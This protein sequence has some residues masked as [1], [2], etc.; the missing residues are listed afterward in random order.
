MSDKTMHCLTC[1][2]TKAWPDGFPDVMSNGACWRCHFLDHIRTAHPET[3]R[4][5][6]RVA[7]KR[8]KRLA[9]NDAL[10]GAFGDDR[11]LLQLAR[12]DIPR[13]ADTHRTTNTEEQAS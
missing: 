3:M 8:A 5:V 11:T 13:P 12:G 2:Q 1:S 10:T 7:K 6:R 4:R 9:L